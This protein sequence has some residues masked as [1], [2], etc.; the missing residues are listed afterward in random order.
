MENVISNKA[1]E[2]VIFMGAVVPRK[3]VVDSRALDIYFGKTQMCL[4]PSQASRLLLDLRCLA[5][6]DIN[7]GVP[8]FEAVD[9]A[10]KDST[11][12]PMLAAALN[13]FRG[14]KLIEN[15][16]R[17]DAIKQKIFEI[18]RTASENTMSSD[19]RITPILAVAA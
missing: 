11:F 2:E 13:F 18:Y 19:F 15:D 3:C 10:P 17:H 7:L 14:L 8:L 1:E 12:M 16:P 5:D 4:R 9:A 6:K